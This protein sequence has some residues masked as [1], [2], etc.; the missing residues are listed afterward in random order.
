MSD[1]YKSIRVNP[2]TQRTQ[3]WHN[4]ISQGTSNPSTPD[5]PYIPIMSEEA[6]GDTVYSILCKST[7]SDLAWLLLNILF[8]LQVQFYCIW[9]M[10]IDQDSVSMSKI[11][12][13]NTVSLEPLSHLSVEAV[14]PKIPDVGTHRGKHKRKLGR[15]PTLLNQRAKL[16][17]C[18]NS[19]SF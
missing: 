12:T 10:F 5:L 18:H 19:W 14:S 17:W 7:Y 2:Y 9:A 16:Q 3:A 11:F 1:L 6:R 8:L 13:E 15:I 4:T